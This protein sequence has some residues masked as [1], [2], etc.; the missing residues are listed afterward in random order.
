MFTLVSKARETRICC[1]HQVKHCKTRYRVVSL[2]G[3]G[4]FGA[5]YKGWDLRL[6]TPVAIKENLDTS[7]EAQRQFQQE[8]LILANLHH[9]NLPRVT[10]HFFIPNSGQYLVMDFIEGEDLQAVLDRSG[11]ALPEAQVLAW[12][13]QV[14]EALAYLHSRLPPVIHR[15]LKP[16]NIKLTPEGRAVLVDFGISK[17][18]DPSLKTTVGARAVTPPYSP[19]EQYGADI[20]DARSDVYALGAT[21]YVLL[22]GQEPPESVTRIANNL[23][24]MPP[25]QLQPALSARIDA[26][27]LRACDVSKTQRFQTMIEFRQA[28][29]GGLPDSPQPIGSP[30]SPH[31]PKWFFAVGGLVAVLLLAI[32]MGTALSN[33]P[34]PM[35][36]VISTAAVVAVVPANT[37]SPT[38]PPTTPTVTPR[39]TVTLEP[40]FTPSPT[41]S[42]PP[43]TGVFASEWSAVQGTLGCATGRAFNGTIVVEEF[44]GGQMIWREPIDTAQ[45]LVL[46]NTGRWQIFR[47]A[48]YVEGSA[49]FACLAPDVP[50][51][52]PP[53]PKR[54]FGLMWCDIA[55]IRSG[56]GK[57]TTCEDSY[58]GAM[59]NFERGFMLRAMHGAILVFYEDGR[60]EQR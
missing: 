1:F 58:T 43:V 53:T 11:Q 30:V 13:D 47:H 60:W 44:V 6:N 2:L 7:P 57:A 56:L 35:P 41:P 48:P 19:P 52:C 38:A 16:A 23:P 36:T 8:A 10:D 33:K 15:D 55:A 32:I 26:A 3:Q 29:R 37:P 50:A 22:T 4:G 39:P 21:L 34:S 28:L 20:T 49:E 18:Y 40:T 46:F 45:A 5:V 42:C 25:R 14:C 17:V 12:I 59:Q 54:G 9:P 51:A 27:I 31:V 24:L